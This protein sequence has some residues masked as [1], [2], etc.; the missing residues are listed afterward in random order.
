[1]DSQGVF[2]TPLVPVQI[3]LSPPFRVCFYHFIVTIILVLGLIPA[4]LILSEGSGS[5]DNALIVF[6]AIFGPSI[7]VYI[8]SVI[9]KKT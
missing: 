8:S 9:L 4:L 5:I 6:S 2:E 3:G 1:M 7:A